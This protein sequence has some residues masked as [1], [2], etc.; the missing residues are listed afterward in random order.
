MKNYNGQFEHNFFVVIEADNHDTCLKFASYI[1]KALEPWFL[2]TENIT[3]HKSAR[4]GDVLRRDIFVK[5]TAF[6]NDIIIFNEML[7]TLIWN[8]NLYFNVK[9]HIDDRGTVPKDSRKKITEKIIND[10]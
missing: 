7:R 9:I 2:Q 3:E 6:A 8:Y 4:K 1:K 5:H 10:K